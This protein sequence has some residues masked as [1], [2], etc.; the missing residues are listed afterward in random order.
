MRPV[1][2]GL[3]LVHSVNSASNDKKVYLMC[4][5]VTPNNLNSE[6]YWYLCVSNCLNSLNTT[7]VPKELRVHYVMV[8][9]K[10]NIFFKMA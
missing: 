2:E 9:I 8:E 7:L 6:F 10:Y 5:F 3:M 1:T 4:P